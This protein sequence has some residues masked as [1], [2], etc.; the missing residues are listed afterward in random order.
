MAKSPQC[1][2][3]KKEKVNNF[4]GLINATK[5]KFSNGLF[6]TKNPTFPGLNVCT[7]KFPTTKGC[8]HCHPLVV[9]GSA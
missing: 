4:T 3:R 6:E 2:K 9:V 5:V 7:L 8:F 1:R